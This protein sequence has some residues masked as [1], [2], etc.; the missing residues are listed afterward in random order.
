M[1]KKKKRGKGIYSR[2]C[3]IM[4]LLKFVQPQRKLIIKYLDCKI[5]ILY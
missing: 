4:E 1:K 2:W 5:T 3:N